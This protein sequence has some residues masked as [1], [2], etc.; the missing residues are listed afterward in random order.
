MG[1]S[2]TYVMVSTVP[3]TFSACPGL[4][5]GDTIPIPHVFG[6]QL[7]TS[8]VDSRAP[9]NTSLA[10]IRRGR[11]RRH[12]H[13]LA[14]WMT[15]GASCQR[16]VKLHGAWLPTGTRAAPGMP[17]SANAPGVGTCNA[18]QGSSRWQRGATA[19]QQLLRHAPGPRN[20]RGQVEPTAV[21]DEPQFLGSE[22]PAK[23][24]AGLCW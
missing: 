5:G 4:F 2:I 12:L 19:M 7:A 10:G 18:W 1:F 13:P 22:P 15:G 16:P 24:R 20:A 23:I 11:P 21:R 17:V 6:S 8:V 14:R 9:V 3:Y